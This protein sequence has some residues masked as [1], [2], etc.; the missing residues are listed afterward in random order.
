MTQVLEYLVQVPGCLKDGHQIQRIERNLLSAALAIDQLHAE[1]PEYDVVLF[2]IN[3][4][5]IKR[6]QSVKPPPICPRG[7]HGL[8]DGKSV[9]FRNSQGK[10]QCGVCDYLGD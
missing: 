5:E 8:R 3:K 4:T 1:Y 6:Y 10:A 9:V 7:H 2:E